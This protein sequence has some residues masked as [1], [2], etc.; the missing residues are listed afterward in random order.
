[1]VLL[2]TLLI[3]AGCGNNSAPKIQ[4][5]EKLSESAYTI[6]YENGKPSTFT[7]VGES[8][9]PIEEGT[10]WL[11]GKA[12][13]DATKGKDSDL[14][15]DVTA[16]KIYFKENGAWTLV[17]GFEI[18]TE[19]PTL[20]RVMELGAFVNK[21][22]STSTVNLTSDNAYILTMDTVIAV[23]Y[24]NVEL[25]VSI[26]EDY[27]LGI[28]SSNTHSKLNTKSEWL[29]NGDSYII[30][31]G[32]IYFRVFVTHKNNV[33]SNN[34][35]IS[36][37]DIDT[38]APTIHYDDRGNNII[39]QNDEAIRYIDVSRGY[40]WGEGKA[41]DDEKY[42]VLVHG[43]DVHGDST[44]LEN[45]LDFADYIDADFTCVSGDLT[46]YELGTGLSAVVDTM[47][48][49][50]QNLI[51][52]IGNHD[53]YNVSRNAAGDG[54]IYD[55]VYG[56]IYKTGDYVYGTVNG[57]P[58]TWYYSDDTEHQIR[59][60]SLN[61][62]ERLGAA[63]GKW[64][65]H[66]NQ[67]QIDFLINALK[68]MKDGWTCLLVY[69]STEIKLSA[70]TS[71]DSAFYTPKWGYTSICPTDYS[72]TV[73]LDIIDAYIG[74]TALKKNYTQ[75]NTY[76]ADGK[77]VKDHIEVNVDFSSAK[78]DFAAHLTGHFHADA[79]CYMPGTTYK[80][81]VLNS[82]CTSA[83]IAN[84][85]GYPYLADLADLPR[86]KETAT[87]NAFNTY[88][89]DTDAKEIRVI[90]IGSNLT[91]RMT[92]RLYTSIS[93]KASAQTGEPLPAPTP[94][95]PADFEEL[96]LISLDP[97]LWLNATVSAT[98]IGEDG[99]KPLRLAYNKVLD[100]PDSKTV[101]VTV[102]G[103]YQWAIRSG[104]SATDLANNQYWYNS[105]DTMTVKGDAKMMLVL[106]KVTN[107]G[108]Q[109]TDTYSI[110]ITDADLEGLEIKIYYKK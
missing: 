20:G 97:S 73:I 30:P 57:E 72:G 3:L 41:T 15:I 63:S 65:V 11:T 96:T 33:E 52:T 77:T 104:N 78:G 108:T 25:H 28:Q 1:M 99:S 10:V 47:T 17:S 55:E 38:I 89:I 40:F 95:I 13:P 4:K 19:S 54:L 22:P 35:T 44:R 98:G 84:E 14:Y 50:D 42:A 75:A 76:A 67:S 43:T 68:T 45:L 86:N 82:T 94:T 31:D 103:M 92:D 61:N 51:V 88:V 7:L 70:A 66:Y 85:G 8:T 100:V 81:V 58:A 74:K 62:F 21:S 6:Y 64:Q 53:V 80:Q 2:F 5:V 37:A 109:G 102:N 9:L 79:I 27:V 26:H 105:G 93:Y 18:Q 71:K 107:L 32:H 16:N 46:A 24:D 23:P 59:V 101:M 34:I 90:R 60:I 69:H 56:K 49:H 29:E 87:Q 12:A 36:P 83:N 106:R 91:Q 39:Y 48:N 110:D